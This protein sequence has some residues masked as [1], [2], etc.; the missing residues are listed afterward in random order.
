[1]VQYCGHRAT[2]VKHIGSAKDDIERALLITKAQAWIEQHSMQPNLFPVQKQKVL[3]I[4][5]GECVAV[6]HNFAYQFFKGCHNDCQLAH[7]PNVLLDLAIIRLIEPA[8]KLR[9]VEL[10]SRYFGI[11]YS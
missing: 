7:L 6:T 1:V 10:L 3:V 2:I 5:R 4:D 11:K 9:S 8:S